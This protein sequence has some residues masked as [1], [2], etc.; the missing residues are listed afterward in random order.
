MNCQMLTA[1]WLKYRKFAGWG[2]PE[3][4][5]E[6][7]TYLDKLEAIWSD[8]CRLGARRDQ[9]QRPEVDQKW[10]AE[11]RKEYLTGH[12]SNLKRNLTAARIELGRAAL[13]FDQFSE[14]LW[15]TSVESFEIEIRKTEAELR[16]LVMPA[17]ADG[18]LTEDMIARAKAYPMKKLL[19]TDKDMVACPFHGDDRH[20]SASIK[21]GFFYCFSCGVSVD[22]IGYLMRTTGIQYKDAILKLQ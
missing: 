10:A 14:A 16:R 8:L 22:A 11:R 9:G 2:N 18:Q 21:K 13:A 5:P 12:A 19:N 3:G 6:E 4:T 1:W 20:P 15:K 17:L 7:E